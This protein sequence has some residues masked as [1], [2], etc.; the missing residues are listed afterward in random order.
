MA[1]LND[2]DSHS[3]SA[4]IYADGNSHS[5]FAVIYVDGDGVPVSFPLGNDGL[6]RVTSLRLS[7]R[8]RLSEDFMFVDGEVYDA[9][10][11]HLINT[12]E[13]SPV[14]DGD[15]KHSLLKHGKYRVYGVSDSIM[16]ASTELVTLYRSSTS[17]VQLT[18][19]SR[20]K[21]EQGE[22]LIT[23]LNDD[24][25]RNSPAV[26]PPDRSPLIISTPPDSMERTPSPITHPPHHVGH[27][28]CLSVV[29]FL[30]RPW[31]SKGA[32]N[33]FRSLDYDSLDIRRVQFFLPTFD[34]D[35]FFEL[36]LVDKSALHIQS[37]LM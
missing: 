3:R 14:C 19:V 29:D 11:G 4:V 22:E 18:L 37:K 36:S 17:I 16:V 23:I 32:K 25:D 10:S 33:A 35:I 1:T 6:A 5:R 8:F 15:S 34:R 20:V 2:G 30:K 7:L 13:Q 27:Q 21:V 26:P 12:I 9:L 24:S 28:K 31:V